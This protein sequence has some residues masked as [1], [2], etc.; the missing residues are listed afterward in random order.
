MNAILIT[1]SVAFLIGLA[2]LPF[3]LAAWLLIAKIT[4]PDPFDD[5]NNP[6]DHGNDH[7]SDD[8]WNN[9]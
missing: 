5:P 1:A 4:Q 7:D 9:Q 8:W 2:T 3:F 6:C